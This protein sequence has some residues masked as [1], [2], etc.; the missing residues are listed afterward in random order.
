VSERARREKGIIFRVLRGEEGTRGK[1]KAREGAENRRRRRQ[2]QQPKS[3]K[4]KMSK[5]MG[6][7]SAAIGVE[8]IED[9]D[10]D[11]DDDGGRDD[12]DDGRDDVFG[13]AKRAGSG[14]RWINVDEVMRGL[15]IG[16]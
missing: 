15:I 14:T 11:D 1:G 12:N 3:F 9:D 4:D 8:R 10:D 6:T 5:R 2:R 16:E 13:E 7:K